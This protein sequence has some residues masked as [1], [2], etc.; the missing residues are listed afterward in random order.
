MMSG[1]SERLYKEGVAAIRAGD[2][3]TARTKLMQVVEMDQT[4]EQAWLWLSAAVDTNDDRLICLQNVLTINPNNE[5]AR[6]GLEKLGAPTTV[7][8]NA[9]GF[10]EEPP[11]EPVLPPEPSR[12]MEHG[13]SRVAE[14]LKMSAPEREFL[15]PASSRVEPE[16]PS[17]NT[18]PAEESWRSALLDQNRE[19]ALPNSA[20]Y[21]REDKGLREPRSFLDLVSTWGEM[22]IFRMGEFEREYRNAGFGHIFINI[23]AAAI[24]AALILFLYVLITNARTPGL[25][26]ESVRNTLTADL[27]PGQRLPQG[28]QDFV[29]LIA[30]P[31]FLTIGL[32]VLVV[33]LIPVFFLGAMLESFVLDRVCSLLK[34]YGDIMQTLHAI[35][36]V[37][38]VQSI[39]QIPILLIT[40]FLSPTAALYVSLGIS[41][42]P[43]LLKARAV[44][45]VHGF[46]MLIGIGALIMN[47]VAM[48]VLVGILFGCFLFLLAFGSS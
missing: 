29:D 35:T 15:A 8:T 34:G 38:V 46:G 27:A 2:K 20:K 26:E 18:L 45:K 21:M 37:M 19:T 25:I 1:D 3:A 48:S 22:L 13:S 5:A 11:V 33:V 43:F 24:L 30:S 16:P 32:A 17:R 40:P 41:L 31:Q 23:V 36:N 10:D 39:A 9:A 7:D 6:K 44:G 4:H 42:Y 28:M 14:S 47:Q 12:R